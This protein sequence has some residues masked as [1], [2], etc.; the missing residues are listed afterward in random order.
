MPKFLT[1]SPTHIPGKK[2]YAWQNFLRG[3][4]A[5][6]GWLPDVNLTGKTIETVI[7][8]IRAEQY[9]NEAAA[10]RSFEKFLA[11]RPSDYIGVNNT[12]DGLFGIGEVRSNY[13][14]EKG[15][16]DTGASDPRDLEEF[17]SHYVDVHWVV[18][19]YT[20]RKAILTEGETG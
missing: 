1:V 2:P 15:K 11:L 18:T 8:L 19:S 3:G 16:H 6:I 20:R 4:Y 12:N 14:Y 7:E 13:K 5:A 17:Y 9:D 10:I